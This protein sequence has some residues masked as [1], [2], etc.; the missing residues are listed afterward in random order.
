L[1]YSDVEFAK[2]CISELVARG[3]DVEDEPEFLRRMDWIRDIVDLLPLVDGLVGAGTLEA[4][5][6]W[7]KKKI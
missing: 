7:L 2:I 5:L 3:I 1:P 6:A 4:T